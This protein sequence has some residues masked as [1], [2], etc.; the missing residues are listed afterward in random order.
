MNRSGQ[1]TVG[2]G[3]SVLGALAI[4]FALT[5]AL[6]VTAFSVGPSPT[7]DIGLLGRRREA[8]ASDTVY[9]PVPET[10]RAVTAWSKMLEDPRAIRWF[11][12]NQFFKTTAHVFGVEKAHQCTQWE[13]LLYFAR[14]FELVGREIGFTPGRTV[15]FAACLLA[16]EDGRLS[17]IDTMFEAVYAGAKTDLGDHLI[18]SGGSRFDRE[19]LVRVKPEIMPVLRERIARSGTVTLAG[20]QDDRIR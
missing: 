1:M 9:E 2:A 3:Q 17:E 20:G 18:F 14:A 12:D 16:L 4:V 15:A 8:H 11:L 10:H 19:F 6:M 5:G 13:S 7:V